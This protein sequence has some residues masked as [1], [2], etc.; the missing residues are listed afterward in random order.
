VVPRDTIERHFP[1]HHGKYRAGGKTQG[2]TRC[3]RSCHS[4]NRDH[5]G[6]CSASAPTGGASARPKTFSDATFAAAISTRG[7]TYGFRIT[8]ARCRTRRKIACSSSAIAPRRRRRRSNYA[9]MLHA[10]S[11][12]RGP[13]DRSRLGSIKDPY[14]G[15][16]GHLLF[17]CP[18][19]GLNV[20][21]WVEDAPDDPSDGYKAVAC[22]ACTKLHF[23]NISNGKLLGETEK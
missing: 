9:A 8:K 1:R 19:T 10:V 7:I 22:Q 20:Q 4:K 13:C 12:R 15:C 14:S 21:H 23:I 5:A 11:P 16:M 17:K 18:Q 6:R 2:A 3:R